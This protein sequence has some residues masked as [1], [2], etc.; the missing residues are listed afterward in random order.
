MAV[1][2]EVPSDVG[3]V[4][5]NER[6]KSVPRTSSQRAFLARFASEQPPSR[7][8]RDTSSVP[9]GD[10]GRSH[11]PE[12]R[13][14]SQHMQEAFRREPSQV[15]DGGWFRATTAAAGGRG[16][17]SSSSSSSDDGES[18]SDL[19][20]NTN[21]D[22]SSSEESL[23]ESHQHQQ[24]K[25]AERRR[26]KQHKH[27]SRK[28]QKALTGVK[29]KSPFN[30]DGTADIDV[31]DKW[32]YEV[33]TWAE[34]NGLDDHLMLKI[35][36]QFMS[37]KPAQFFMRHVATYR[38]KW[39]MKRLYEA[40]FDYCFPPDYKASL[41][42]DLEHA[43]QGER[44]GVRDFVRKIQHLAI[45]F[46]DVTDVQLVHIFWHGV[47][48]H[49]RLHL[50]EKGYDPE[51]TKLDRLVKHA[52]RREKAY[53]QAQKEERAFRGKVPGRGWG[54]FESRTTGPQP[55]KPRSEQTDSQQREKRGKDLPQPAFKSQSS[56][57]TSSAHASPSERRERKNPL[58]KEE[59][60]RLRSEGRCFACKE[61]G[62][63]S[64][65]CPAR[66][67]AKAPAL[68]T[69]SV[70]FTELEALADRARNSEPFLRV[71]AGDLSTD[72]EPQ[73]EGEFPDGLDERIA[74]T[75][76]KMFVR[77]YD[78]RDA[79]KAGMDP[80]DRFTVRPFG[81]DAYE[82]SDWLAPRGLPSDYLVTR[83]QL[84]EEDWG[85]EEIVQA[86]WD[87]WISIPPRKEWGTG[88]PPCDP[89]WETHPALFW[90]RA[91]VSAQG[92][93]LVKVLPHEAG[94]LVFS[95]WLDEER[96]VLT[97]AEVCEPSF[98]PR[99]VTRLVLDEYSAADL[100]RDYSSHER[101]M[102]RRQAL[103]LGAVR[104]GRKPKGPEKS[105]S[106]GRQ[107]HALERNAM[108]PKDYT[109]TVP[110]PVV[111]EATVNGHAVRALLDTGSMADFLSTTI[112]D[113]LKL[114]LETL[115]T[116]ASHARGDLT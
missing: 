105:P 65:N 80:E 8:S 25:D 83:S 27:D 48:Q 26:R 101:R 107:L 34:L 47:H 72:P 6:G 98:D 96:H 57:K 88:F 28:L 53:R 64:R 62:H 44:E 15:P 51:T 104:P 61:T 41:R 115:G 52:V 76:H 54:R 35:V 1:I 103:M 9:S 14:D 81:E 113:Q 66:K 95:P 45:R 84:I 42:Y 10:G 32:T 68:S 43:E 77:Y 112:A 82:V 7:Q 2:S 91:H 56:R 19:G 110:V 24:K 50:I 79:L 93:Q 29:L 63:E 116:R 100:R 22:S 49:I 90:L 86:E 108:K 60:Q 40:L 71:S 78:P 39:T 18:G 87:A 23:D 111:V 12:R 94:Y 114:D 11:Y 69:S 33:D 37:G 46:P 109:R 58:S 17:P 30:Y 59:M 70:R 16:P 38:S 106:A 92:V 55:W 99:V 36:V 85:V 74:A 102:K 3:D 89:R 75:L 5:P 4:K 73:A 13:P 31:F 97:H 20:P 67:R 21:H